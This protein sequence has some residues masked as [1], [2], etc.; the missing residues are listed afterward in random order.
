MKF[1]KYYETSRLEAKPGC[2]LT[3]GNQLEFKRWARHHGL[4]K[5]NGADYYFD[6]IYPVDATEAKQPDIKG[7][8]ADGS[9]TWGEALK[10]LKK[11]FKIKG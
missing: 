5:K 2:T 9:T 4:S 6:S 7:F 1:Y 11:H 3:M 8:F 10:I